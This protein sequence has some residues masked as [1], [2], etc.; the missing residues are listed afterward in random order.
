MKKLIYII[1]MLFATQVVAQDYSGNV[2]PDT[3][4]LEVF[5]NKDNHFAFMGISFCQPTRKFKKEL[6]KKGWKMDEENNKYYSEKLNN[7]T[8]R[9]ESYSG[10]FI[11]ES[12]TLNLVLHKNKFVMGVQINLSYH[13]KELALEKMDSIM[14]S[15]KEKYNYKL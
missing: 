12:A 1:A 6:K 5:Q 8:M 7:S 10:S 2:L 14:K 9:I 11:G 13:N 4:T 15:V 3:A